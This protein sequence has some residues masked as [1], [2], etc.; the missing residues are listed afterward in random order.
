MQDVQEIMQTVTHLETMLEQLVV[1]GVRSSGGENINALSNMREQLAKIGA[2]H[3]SEKIGVVVDALRGD[4]SKAAR[5]IL[6][7]QASLRVFD[8][9]LTL[10]VA[11]AQ[12]DAQGRF[13]NVCES[14][15]GEDDDDLETESD[16][17]EP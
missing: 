8:R 14:G 5:A 12:L 6:G 4:S 3:L 7:A 13:D 1:R 10:E 11:A 2:Q 15:E 17:D 9:L 16:E